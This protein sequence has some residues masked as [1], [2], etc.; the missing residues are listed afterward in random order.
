MWKGFGWVL[1]Q[2]EALP[3]RARCPLKSKAS[4]Q[5]NTVTSAASHGHSMIAT[6]DEVTADVDAK[7]LVDAE[8]EA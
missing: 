2:P 4:C 8:I 6:P 5:G 3:L 7:V 1:D